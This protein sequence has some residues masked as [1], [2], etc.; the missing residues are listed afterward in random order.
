MNLL[1]ILLVVIL[2]LSV[3]SGFVAGFARVGISFIAAIA[4]LL[5]GFWFYGIPAATLHKYLSS[6]MLSNVLGFLLIF[7]GFSAVGAL[8]GKLI[9][10]FFKATGLSWLDRIL[11]A[12]FGF[13]RG[14]LMVVAFVAV[15]MAFTPKPMPN[16]MVDSKVLPYAV[17][18]SD[19][20]ASL[21]PRALKDAFD[22]GLREIRKVWDEQMKE[23]KRKTHKE[24]E[25]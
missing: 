14:A 17:D 8:I 1:D 4:G 23:Y 3:A 12:G 20:C 13:V 24:G 18:A 2:A 21:A 16:W 19:L 10:K 6:E 15:L 9:S 7:L 5:F 11:G 25:A 22:D